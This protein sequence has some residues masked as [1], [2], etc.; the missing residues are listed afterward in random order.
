MQDFKAGQPDE[1]N[2]KVTLQEPRFVDCWF[3]LVLIFQSI[4][5]HRILPFNIGFIF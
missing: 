1:Q 4:D 3:G 5:I 2:L